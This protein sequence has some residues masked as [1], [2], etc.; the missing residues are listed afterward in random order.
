MMD[1]D[2][3]VNVYNNAR[4]RHYFSQNPLE[5]GWISSIHTAFHKISLRNEPGVIHDAYSLANK[6]Q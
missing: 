1:L 5:I 6:G 4:M 3:M 2:N